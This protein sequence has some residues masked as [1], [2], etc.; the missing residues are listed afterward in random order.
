MP[1]QLPRKGMNTTLSLLLHRIALS[2]FLIIILSEI[3]K[4]P[5]KYQLT[6]KGQKALKI[7]IILQPMSGCQQS[8]RQ[9]TG[10]V[11]FLC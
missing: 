1:I 2:I 3:G 11:C 6:A 7:Q 10:V 8:I 9:E 5:T 4:S